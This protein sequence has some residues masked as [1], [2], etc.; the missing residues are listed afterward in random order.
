MILYVC[1]HLVCLLPNPI[2]YLPTSIISGPPITTI[3]NGGNEFEEVRM[4][5]EKV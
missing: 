3:P 5:D 2:E 4:V 1:L